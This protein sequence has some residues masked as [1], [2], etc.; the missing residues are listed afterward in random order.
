MAYVTHTNIYTHTHKVTTDSSILAWK[1]LWT[2][3]PGGPRSI[4][5]QRIGQDY[6]HMY[7]CIYMKRTHIQTV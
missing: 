7:A 5:S 1:I 6:A 3:K 2:K 4:G